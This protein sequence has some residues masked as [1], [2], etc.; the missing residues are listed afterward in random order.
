MA[1]LC[2]LTL[3][4]LPAIALAE[5]ARGYDLVVDDA[6]L[7]TG[8]EMQTLNEK[9]WRL[10]QESNMEFVIYTA[11]SNLTKPYVYGAT[12]PNSYDCSGLTQSCFKKASVTL[13]RSAYSQGYDT[14][15][16][17]I[18]EISKLKRGD[19][20]FFNTITDS[21]LCDHVGIYLGGYCFIHA[22]SGGK[23]V[24]VSSL[25]SGYYN[26]VFSWGRRIM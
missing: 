3:L 24:V 15:Y 6:N 16:T 11:Q 9:A 18:S 17:K 10:S 26:R 23:K 12:G 2:A 20:V 5:S 22:S 13:K 1:L 25:A 14:T 8:D 7:L 19:L 4:A 21:D